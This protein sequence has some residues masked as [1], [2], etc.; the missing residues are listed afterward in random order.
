MHLIKDHHSLITC[1]RDLKSVFKI[2]INFL[3]INR[4]FKIN[5][6]NKFK[7]F[8]LYFRYYKK[9]IYKICL[10]INN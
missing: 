10:L 9:K 4:I 5:E 7:I 3:L 2:E 6:L 8:P 1:G